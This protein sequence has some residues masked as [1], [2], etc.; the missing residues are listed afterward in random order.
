[1]LS[2]LFL[3]VLSAKLSARFEVD[4]AL[5]RLV[6]ASGHQRLCRR[7]FGR[8]EPKNRTNCHKN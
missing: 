8:L 3:E 1:L 4:G 6:L 2:S 7:H 5:L